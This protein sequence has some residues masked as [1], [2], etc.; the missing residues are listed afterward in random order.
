MRANDKTGLIHRIKTKAIER[1]FAARSFWKLAAIFLVA[2][3]AVQLLTGCGGE[4]SSSGT[5]SKVTSIDWRKLHPFG[6][7]ELVYATQFQVDFLSSYN[8]DPKGPEE[9]Y[10][11]VTIADRDKYLVVPEGLPVPENLDPEIVVLQKPLQNVYQAASSVMDFF[12]KLDAMDQIAMT[13]TKSE[14]WSIPEI[15]SMIKEG[16]IQYGGKYSAPDY[17]RIMEL[18]SSLAIES[19]MIY[20]TPEV[21]EEL[22]SFGIPVLVDHSSKEAHPLGRV[23]WIRLYGLLAGRYDEAKA[24]MEDC[25]IRF[26]QLEAEAEEAKD[27]DTAPPQKVSFFYISNNA[28][29]NV[30]KPGDYISKMIDMAGG[31]YIFKDIPVEEENAMSTINIQMEAFYEQMVDADI[32]IYNSTVDGELETVGELLE[33]CPLLADLPAV[34]KGAC[35]C[36]GKNMYQ[37]TTGMIGMLED[38]YAVIHD[39]DQAELTYLHKLKAE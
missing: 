36:T 15:K 32:L 17:E 30:R 7:M 4:A 26:D 6:S 12:L 35:F 1:G 27:A 29:A 24:F 8:L 10:S 34:K 11:L 22:E 19:T 20:H 14:D 21:K 2:Y 37:E 28:Y 38:F 39:G 33:K 5:E 13:G 9:A 18:G 25:Q 31:D 3:L 23:E 16:Q